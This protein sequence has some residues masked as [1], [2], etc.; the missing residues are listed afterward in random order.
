MSL[1]LC[2]LFLAAGIN[3]WIGGT[4]AFGCFI[5]GRLIYG[6][7]GSAA[8]PAVQALVAGETSRQDRTRALTLLASAFGLGTILGPA[9]AP[10]LL[11]G[12]IGGVEIGLAGPAF[13]FALFGVGVWIAVRV[14]LTSVP[15]NQPWVPLGSSILRHSL[16]VSTTRTGRSAR[17]YSQVAGY[18]RPGPLRIRALAG[19]IEA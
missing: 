3:G 6:T 11:L 1:G 9:I 15:R 5:G 2:G 7:F 4:A 17:T 10:Y 12:T 19:A 8:P 13:V 18:V 14:L 16:N